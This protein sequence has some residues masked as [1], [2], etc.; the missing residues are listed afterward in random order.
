MTTEQAGRCLVELAAAFPSVR[1][2]KET[3]AVWRQWLEALPHAEAKRAVA[4][5]CAQHDFPTVHQLIAACGISSEPV[6]AMLVAAKDGGFEIVRDDT[7]K[8]GWRS[9][10][11]ALTEPVHEGVPCPPDI[12]EQIK[13]YIGK[14]AEKRVPSVG[15]R[16]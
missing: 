6:L 3:I 1:L 10:R 9:S 2:P 8:H 15:V 16:P 12:R 5:V 4:L 13:G 7:D 11:G 14:L